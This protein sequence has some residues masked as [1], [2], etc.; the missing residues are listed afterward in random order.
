MEHNPYIVLNM[1]SVTS[2]MNYDPWPGVDACLSI[3]HS[4]GPSI[5]TFVACKG[6]GG[7]TLLPGNVSLSPNTQEITRQGP[8]SP[9]FALVSVVW[10]A[11]EIR[12]A[13]VY[14]GLYGYHLNASAVP[15]ENTVFG[16]DTFPKMKKSGVIWYTE[17]NFQTFKSVYSREGFAVPF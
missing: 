2:W 5:R 13:T 7:F 1:S 14:E 15:F 8:S 6:Q 17:D 4:Y 9:S 10:G 12:D 3:L 16:K 11:R